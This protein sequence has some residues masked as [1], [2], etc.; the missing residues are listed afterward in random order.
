MYYLNIYTAVPW[1]GLATPQ[2][3]GCEPVLVRPDQVILSNSP[4]TSPGNF[5]A[6]TLTS[7][8]IS[9]NS[10][11]VHSSCRLGKI[12][13][14]TTSPFRHTFLHCLHH[15][16]RIVR[17]CIRLV[18]SCEPLA[19]SGL[20]VQPLG[21]PLLALIHWSAQHLPPGLLG[22]M[23][24]LL[25]HNGGYDLSNSTIQHTQSWISNNN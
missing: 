11:P 23:V 3:L 7:S 17:S 19:F 25:E 6:S 4:P 24:P 9:T 5:S 18:Y 1:P 12:S 13:F 15:N 14:Y 20:L 8:T 22:H 10:S 16:F 21:V 2:L